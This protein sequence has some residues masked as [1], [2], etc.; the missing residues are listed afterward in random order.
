MVRGVG[1]GWCEMSWPL[2]LRII[3]WNVREA[4]V[5]VERNLKVKG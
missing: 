4:N 2:M 5:E 3:S 1:S